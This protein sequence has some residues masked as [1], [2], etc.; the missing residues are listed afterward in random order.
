MVAN[1]RVQKNR[2]IVIQKENRQPNLFSLELLSTLSMMVGIKQLVLHDP[3]HPIS[4]QC[5]IEFLSVSSI[6]KSDSIQTNI[7]VYLKIPDFLNVHCS[8]QLDQPIFRS[9]PDQTE[10]VLLKNSLPYFGI[11]TRLHGTVHKCTNRPTKLRPVL[12]RL[13]RPEW[14]NNNGPVKYSLPHCTVFLLLLKFLGVLNSS[15]G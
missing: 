13:D 4:T 12:S 5:F 10:L 14:I 1:S 6:S 3:S 2:V 15:V 9:K 8:A 7:L 11:W